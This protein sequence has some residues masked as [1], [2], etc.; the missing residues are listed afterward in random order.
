MRVLVVE[1]D[2]QT[3]DYLRDSLDETGCVVD[4]AADG[5][6]GLT[7]ARAEPFDVLIVDRMLPKLDGLALVEALRADEVRTPVLFLTAMGSIADKV[8]GLEGGGDDYLVKPFSLAELKARVA[9]L[10]RRPA[11]AAREST[12]LRVG[13]LSL[14]RL[15]RR[16]RRGEAEVELLPLQYK[17]LE[18]LMLNEGR[19]VTRSMLLEQV[20]GIRFD[21]GTNIVETHISHL[22]AKIDAG[23]QP[24]LITTVRGAGY[25]LRGR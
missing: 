6:A 14:N 15:Q 25:V 4:L 7:R 19:I 5:E 11:L 9:A 18:F 12:A 8:A 2:R 21:P 23:E 10:A 17:L 1:D 22:R 24:S 13:D 16:V 20:W 3:A